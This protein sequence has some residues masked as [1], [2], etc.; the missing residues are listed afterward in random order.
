M[1]YPVSRK[2]TRMSGSYG[3]R[4]PIRLPDGSLTPAWHGGVD[5]TPLRSGSR[6]P[7]YAVGAGTVVIAD[8][9]TSPSDFSGMDIGIRLADRSIWWYGHLSRVD[10]NVGQR[11]RDGQQIGLMGATGRVTGVHLHLERHWP[12]LN[13]E[14]DPWPYIEH[15]LWVLYVIAIAPTILISTYVD[16]L[17]PMHAVGMSFGFAVA[18]SSVVLLAKRTTPARPLVRRISHT[19]FW[20]VISGFSLFVYGYLA[21][22]AGLSLRFLSIFEVYDV[23]E[24]YAEVLAGAG[25]LGYLVSPQ[26]N[27]VNPIIM[28]AGIYSRRWW[29]VGLGVIGQLVLYSGTGLKSILFSMLAVVILAFIF[30]ANLRPRGILL[31]GG[32]SGLI[33]VTA[34]VNIVQGSVVWSSLFARR[35]LITP[36]RLSSHYVEFYSAN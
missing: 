8:R 9:T 31:L 27:V 1:A 36:A 32:A 24:D 15:E 23:R 34:W 17:D 19:S 21:L 29:L 13:V 2:L 7:V 35:F 26:A 20:L 28:A 5:F 3:P 18:F 16:V 12:A 22:T 14:T 11:V 6:L 30:R 10:V 33:A 4:Q 25:L